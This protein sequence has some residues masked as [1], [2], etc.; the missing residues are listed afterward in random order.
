[1]E[2][3]LGIQKY[4][5]NLLRLLSNWFNM[6]LI[7]LLRN[8]TRSKF[9]SK[10]F[11]PCKRNIIINGIAMTKIAEITIIGNEYRVIF[12]STP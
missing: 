7:I 8:P 4:E 9:L 1:M 11:I 5:L 2:N 6:F 12:F 3:L 10:I